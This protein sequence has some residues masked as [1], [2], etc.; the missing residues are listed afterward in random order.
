MTRIACFLIISL[1]SLAMIAGC[2]S[3]GPSSGVKLSSFAGARTESRDERGLL[4]ESAGERIWS[5]QRLASRGRT[6]MAHQI[7]LLIY[8][9]HEPAPEV[10][11]AAA[12]ASGRL[13]TAGI[14]PMIA[15]GLDDPNAVVRIKSARA[16]GTVGA[17]GYAEALRD[18]M[19]SEAESPEARIEAA[20]AL[21]SA[22]DMDVAPALIDALGD[23]DESLALA[24]Y[25][26]LTRL[27]DVD[28]GMDSLRWQSWWD[29]R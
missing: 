20:L 29:E 13:G 4:S 23:L 10:R 19:M 14:A 25:R 9:N 5:I 22:G 1:A 7:A 17:A 27:T 15:R 3:Y 6:D 12:V 11:A 28:L 26:S 24:S 21:G 18:M 16:L 8:R 2:R